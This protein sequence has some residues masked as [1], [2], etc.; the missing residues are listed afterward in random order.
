MTTTA[1]TWQYEA[2][3]SI[4][5]ANGDDHDLRIRGNV[6]PFIPARI[7]G[8]PE[9]CSPAEGGEVEI[10]EVWDETRHEK[11]D[12]DD[13]TEDDLERAEDALRAQADDDEPGYDESRDDDWGMEP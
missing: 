3:I 11:F 5:M 12:A 10:V 1:R 13:L 4:E 6:S 8:P 7:H 9:N 2:G